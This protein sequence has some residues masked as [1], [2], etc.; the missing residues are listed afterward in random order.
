MRLMTVT[1]CISCVFVYAIDYYVSSAGSDSNPGTPELPFATIQHAFDLFAHTV[2]LDA[3]TWYE[4]PNIIGAGVTLIGDYN[5]PNGMGGRTTSIVNGTIWT[6]TE[7]SSPPITIKFLTATGIYDQGRN[8]VVDSCNFNNGGYYL[9]TYIN[10]TQVSILNCVFD[11]GGICIG[12][13]AACTYIDNNIINNCE[14]EAI[15]IL[16]NNTYIYNNNIY[17]NQ[18]G[19]HTI[20]NSVSIHNN[21]IH[22]NSLYGIKCS[23]H[24]PIIFSNTI[25]DNNPYGIY[26]T[27]DSNPDLG[28]GAQSCTGNNTISGNG[29]YE[30][31][32]ESSNLIFAKYNYWDSLSE[33]EMMGH[34]YDQ[35]NVTRIFDHWDDIGN[36]YVNWNNPGTHIKIVPSSIGQIKAAYR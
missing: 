13:N 17:N 6:W 18:G 10:D 3:S 22:N 29:T 27:A 19:I 12:P 31:Y 23:Y 30:I 2:H 36:G 32:N 7:F 33:S 14:G 34:T 35:V 24:S 16:S 1:L 26:I 28:G 8:I 21:N 5:G 20:V 9:Q 15:Y 4:S 25:I 11:H